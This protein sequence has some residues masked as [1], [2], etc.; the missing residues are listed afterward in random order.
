M[1]IQHFA[2]KT[3]NPCLR[4]DD[5]SPILLNFEQIPKYYESIGFM[6]NGIIFSVFFKLK[7]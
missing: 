3:V 4:G 7:G 6:R 1:T 2:L 5:A